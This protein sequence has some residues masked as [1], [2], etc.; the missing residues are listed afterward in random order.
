MSCFEVEDILKI[1]KIN[2]L[3]YIRL[4]LSSVYAFILLI[5]GCFGALAGNFCTNIPGAFLGNITRIWFLTHD[6]GL[7]EL[8]YQIIYNAVDIF[9]ISIIIIIAGFTYISGVIIKIS[10]AAFG[11][12]QGFALCVCLDRLNC[13]TSS[14][15]MGGLLLCTTM[16]I[17]CIIVILNSVNAA[18]A[19]EEFSKYKNT[20]RLLTSGSF[21]RY[22]GGFLAS[23]GYVLMTCA[24][25]EL[26][27]KEIL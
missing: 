3:G 27:I 7:F 10:V 1:R 17:Y 2:N 12:S 22:I 25:Y 11:F 20:S 16:V 6:D 5:F 4:K 23:F 13:N 18:V 8:I 19:A 9:K 26:I 24:A 14:A 15:R 21:W